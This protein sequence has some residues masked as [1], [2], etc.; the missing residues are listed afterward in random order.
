MES[1]CFVETSRQ[2]QERRQTA[3]IYPARFN[4]PDKRRLFPMHS[5]ERL[6]N[7]ICHVVLPIL[8]KS[9]TYRVLEKIM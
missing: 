9:L 3:I 5:V 7:Q 4:T 1:H 8:R 2:I 6:T